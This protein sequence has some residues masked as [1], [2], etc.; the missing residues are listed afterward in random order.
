MNN[1][2]FE[3]LEAIGQQD[4]IDLDRCIDHLSFN[5]QGLIPVI[6]QCHE[7]GAV[8]MQAWMNRAAIEKTLASG[9]MTYWSRSRG[10]F[11]QKGASSGHIQYLK[12]MHFD[13]DGD[14]LLCLVEQV[15]AACH[16]GRISCFY[17]QVDAGDNQV[18]LCPSPGVTF[19]RPGQAP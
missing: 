19:S 1:A 6:A 10:E 5:A 16:T 12:R 17:L 18:Q 13:C 2:F 11:W 15:G 3:S 14:A 4:R 8:L 9:R 7:S